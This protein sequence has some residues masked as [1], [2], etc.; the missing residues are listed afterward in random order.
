MTA[1]PS[2]R[3]GSWPTPGPRWGRADIVLAD[4]GAVKIWMA[5]L[6]PTYEP[7]TA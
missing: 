7:S 4:T 5:R 1:S 6:Y 3:S 2:S